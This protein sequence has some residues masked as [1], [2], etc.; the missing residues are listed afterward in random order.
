MYYIDLIV[1]VEGKTKKEI[2]AEIQGGISGTNLTA[3]VLD[4][5]FFAAG[6]PQVRYYG[7][8]KQELIE[9]LRRYVDD[10]EWLVEE[11]V[12]DIKKVI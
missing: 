12:E 5:N 6:W 4:Y 2:D 8:D 1:C 7:S 9:L 10:E 3:K 11:Y